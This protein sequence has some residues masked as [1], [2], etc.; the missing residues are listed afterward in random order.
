LNVETESVSFYIIGK[1][2]FSATVDTIKSK[3]I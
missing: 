2:S 1:E 3:T